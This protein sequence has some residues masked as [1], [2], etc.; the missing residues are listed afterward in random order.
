MTDL[1]N[2]FQ[3]TE[4][5]KAGPSEATPSPEPY[6]RSTPR[7]SNAGGSPRVRTRLLSLSVLPS[8]ARRNAGTR[9]TPAHALLA[10]PTLPRRR[11]HRA[12]KKQQ[13]C[14]LV[15]AV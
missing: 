3:G 13:P 8:F 6:P 9:A 4:K 15:R 2:H 11:P 5:A 14:P 7:F 12:Y 10:P 1:N